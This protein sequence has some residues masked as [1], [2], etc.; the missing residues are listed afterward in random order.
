LRPRRPCSDQK[1][2]HC[3][4]DDSLFHNPLPP[5]VHWRD[6]AGGNSRFP[7]RTLLHLFDQT[8]RKSGA[9]FLNLRL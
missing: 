8:R 1:T 2:S 4:C 9:I 5:S 7:Y 6:V 3:R